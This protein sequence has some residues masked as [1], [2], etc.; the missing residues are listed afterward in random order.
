MPNIYCKNFMKKYL[1]TI[2]NIH[3]HKY[4]N[5]IAMK[6]FTPPQALT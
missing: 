3:L 6:T 4:K 1:D 5:F 2:F